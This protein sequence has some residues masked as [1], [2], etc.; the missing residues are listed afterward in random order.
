MQG[1]LEAVEIEKGLDMAANE[2][3]NAIMFEIDCIEHTYNFSP[4]KIIL[5]A[6]I[7]AILRRD[8]RFDYQSDETVKRQL[9]GM[10]VD[11]DYVDPNCIKICMEWSVMIRGME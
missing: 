3:I 4:N 5:G 2:I 11:I 1:L 10:D 7:M 9:M 6:D 8:L